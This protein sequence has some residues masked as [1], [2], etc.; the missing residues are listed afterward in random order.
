[1]G[2]LCPQSARRQCVSTT[3]S[4]LISDSAP[5]PSCLHPRPA[6]HSS[7]CSNLSSPFYSVFCRTSLRHALVFMLVSFS[8]GM[9]RSCPN[10]LHATLSST[11]HPPVMMYGI[12]WL[13]YI[14]DILV[15]SG[16]SKKPSTYGN[17]MLHPWC[18][19]RV[20]SLSAPLFSL[21]GISRRVGYCRRARL[22][23]CFPS[24][25][26][27]NHAEPLSTTQAQLHRIPHRPGGS[28]LSPDDRGKPL[29]AA[30]SRLTDAMP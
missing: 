19:R 7:D 3:L 20:I 4:I 30:R 1:M 21:I 9:V 29:H 12:H 2:D 8:I 24:P 14:T 25:R 17:V 10:H 6:T 26:R 27:T 11:P 18:H 23:P 5:S 28:S 15:S 22:S 13:Q 16:I